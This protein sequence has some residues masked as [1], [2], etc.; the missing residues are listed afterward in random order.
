MRRLQK[1]LSP[2]DFPK[3]ERPSFISLIILISSIEDKSYTEVAPGK[4]PT[5]AGSPVKANTSSIPN[6]DKPNK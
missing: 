4:S 6:A 3:I 1:T 5:R 2:I